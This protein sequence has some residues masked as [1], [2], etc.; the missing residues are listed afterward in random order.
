M[1]VSCDKEVPNER[2]PITASTANGHCLQNMLIHTKYYNIIWD[3]HENHTIVHHGIRT[4]EKVQNYII[5]I[6]YWN[7]NSFYINLLLC[8]YSFVC[9]VHL[10]NCLIHLSILF[11]LLVQLLIK[12]TLL[13]V[14]LSIPIHTCLSWSDDKVLPHTSMFSQIFVPQVLTTTI[15]TKYRCNSVTMVT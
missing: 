1:V 11:H 9:L 8:I 15:H 3:L 13:S 14:H 4:E 12:S 5:Y 7:V 2:S 10:L 6:L